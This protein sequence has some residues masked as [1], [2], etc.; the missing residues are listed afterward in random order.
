MPAGIHSARLDTTPA[1]DPAMMAAVARRGIW[2]LTL[3]T[4]ALWPHAAQLASRE[5]DHAA[6][7]AG[8]M[9]AAE[10]SDCHQG[11]Q[12]VP[13]PHCL[14]ESGVLL[15]LDPG[16]WIG[17]TGYVGNDM[18]T[19]IRQGDSNITKGSH[20][21]R[22]EAALAAELGQFCEDGEHRIAGGLVCDVGELLAGDGR[23]AGAAAV[24]GLRVEFA[25]RESGMFHGCLATRIPSSGPVFGG[26]AA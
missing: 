20:M 18:I 6:A 21:A 1:A 14:S 16:S 24:R 19:P 22:D 10:L 7:Q 25:L 12:C 17:D 11:R 9:L 15:T 23:A 4:N 3:A 5:A 13:Q 8:T 26:A 2:D